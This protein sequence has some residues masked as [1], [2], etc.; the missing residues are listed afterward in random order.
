MYLYM[1]YIF[2]QLINAICVLVFGGKL[3]K[4]QTLYAVY[5]AV[6]AE[7]SRYVGIYCSNNLL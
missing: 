5:Q 1:C 7:R 6:L 4:D 2:S 3:T